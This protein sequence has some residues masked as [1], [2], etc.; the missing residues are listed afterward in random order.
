MPYSHPQPV[1][2]STVYR[3]WKHILPGSVALAGT[4][5]YINSVVLGFFDTPVSHMSGA[6]SR[7]GQYVVERRAL[8]S[9]ESLSIVFGFVLGSIL[10]GALIGATKLVPARRYGFA[11]MLEG[12][13]LL[14]ATFLLFEKLAVGLVLAAVACGLQNAMS[15]S[16]CGL[17]IRTTH[18]TGTVTDLGVMI[19]HWLRHRRVDVIKFRLLLGLLLSF[20]G[21]GVVGAICNVRYGP[22]CLVAA[23]VGCFV[24]GATFFAIMHQ[25]KLLDQGLEEEATPSEP[26]LT[27]P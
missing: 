9:F 24:A 7:L 11:L 13:I 3:E 20:G 17:A 2:K 5:G 10:G 16:Y 8:E 4:A 19:G 15:S 14:L 18:I 6:V 21:G 26:P 22:I 1:E 25:Q 12:V 23:A 27:P